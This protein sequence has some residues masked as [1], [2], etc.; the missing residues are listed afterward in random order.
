MSVVRT[1]AGCGDTSSCRSAALADA[2]HGR[3]SCAKQPQAA[4]QGLRRA[5]RAQDRVRRDCSHPRARHVHGTRAAYV[6]DRCRC[7]D[8]TAANTAACRAASRAQAFDRWH[9]FVDAAPVRDH[10]RALRAAGIGVERIAAVAGIAT[11]HVRA[12]ADQ[13]RFG[14]PSIRRVRPETAQR[15]LTVSVAAVTRAG[16]ARVDATG[17]RRR[18]QALV[19]IGWSEGQ[20]AARLH[21]S[22]SSLSRSMISAAV[23]GQTA[24]DVG[25]LYQRLW[26]TRPPQDTEAQRA[27]VDAAKARAKSCGWLPPLAWDDIDSDPGPGPRPARYQSDEDIDHIAIERAI[28]GDGIRLNQLTRVEQKEVIHHLTRSGRSIHD[29]AAQLGTTKRTV[30]RRRASLR[31]P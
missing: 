10:V 12:L 22:A 25:T 9:P 28:A 16:G 15:V 30:S 3:P 21:R 20:L 29:I 31:I 1:C 27:A 18:L 2:Q 5:E 23:T 24:G 26:N 8:C 6:K 13:G 4:V 11:S 14:K 17:T 7:A 19:A